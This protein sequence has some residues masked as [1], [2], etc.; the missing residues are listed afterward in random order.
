MEF[1]L[2]YNLL[3]KRSDIL[4]LSST[5]KPLILIECKAPHVSLN[6]DVLFQL[7]TYNSKIQSKYLIA[8]NGMITLYWKKS[9]GDYISINELPK[10][11]T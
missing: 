7:A 9:I 5:L 1:G 2:K 8:T 4:V 10:K 6:N 3:D 11:L